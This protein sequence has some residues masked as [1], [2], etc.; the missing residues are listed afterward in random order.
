MKR[1]LLVGMGL[2]LVGGLVMP[3]VTPVGVDPASAAVAGAAMPYDFD[4]DGYAD[5]TVGVPFEDLRGVKNAGAVQVLFGSPAGPTA[6]DQAWHQ[7]SKG[8]KGA[9]ERGDRF[10][11]VLASGD[12]DADG[13]A[14]LAVG[15]PNEDVGSVR[16]AGV[17]QVL[18]GG[19]RGLTARDQVWHPGKP[20]VPGRNEAYNN[21]GAKLASGDFDADGYADL[22]VGSPVVVLRGGRGGLS[23]SAAQSWRRS[24]GDILGQPA[25]DGWAAE[26]ATGDVNGDGHDDLAIARGGPEGQG[27]PVHLLMG[28]PGG[29]TVEGSQY[30]L[31]TDLNAVLTAPCCTLVFADFNRDDH[32][33]LVVGSSASAAVLYGHV[34]GLHPGPLPPAEVVAPGVDAM[35]PGLWGDE[36]VADPVAAGDLTGDGYLDL[37]IGREVVLGTAGGLGHELRD[38]RAIPGADFGAS[39]VL[40]LSGSGQEWLAMTSGDSALPYDAGAVAV[41]QG[42][43]NGD[44]GAVT[45]WSQDSRGIRGRAERYDEFGFSIG[46]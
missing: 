35:W 45:L 3:A 17:V 37:I 13:Y 2:V 19:P 14:D 8:V 10:G 29:L 32:A 5:L 9:P 26:L 21:F 41:V 28:S 22:V 31:S 25:W 12:F 23:A 7:G 24:P 4:G 38:W 16:D 46:G 11:S 30:F 34:D 36:D 40:P 33:D 42:T 27:S 1:G 43:A 15:I 6:R 44:V 20:G 39:R 18:Y